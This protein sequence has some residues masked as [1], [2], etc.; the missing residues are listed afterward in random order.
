MLVRRV[1]GDSPSG[2]LVVWRRGAGRVPSADLVAWSGVAGHKLDRDASRVGGPLAIALLRR[3]LWCVKHR[4]CV[5]LR[6]LSIKNIVGLW[7][8]C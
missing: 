1:P 2:D 4:V 8:D 6:I 3:H 5:I 7:F